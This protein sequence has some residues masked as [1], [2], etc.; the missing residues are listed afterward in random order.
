MRILMICLDMDPRSIQGDQHTGAA[1]LYVR[2]TLDAL[3]ESGIETLAITRHND[4]SK[5]VIEKYSDSV[6]IVRIG[7]G[8]VSVEP[9]E[10]LWGKESISIGKIKAVLADLNF[11]PDIIHSIYWYSGKVGLALSKQLGLPHVYT[12]ISLGKVKHQTLGK[13]LVSHDVDRERTEQECFLQS[14]VIISVCQQEKANLLKL[15]PGVDPDKIVVVGRGIDPDL[16]F[17]TPQWPAE[18]PSIKKPYLF[19]AARLIPSKGLKFLAGVYAR[20]LEDETI[21]DSPQLVIAG[22][23]S[24]E[25]EES[26]LRILTTLRH[27]TAF[28]S[29]M[30]RWLGIVPRDRMPV[31][32]SNAVLTCVPS[33][34][35]PAARVVLESMA[36]ETPVLMTETGYSGEVVL[37]GV[38]GFVAEYGDEALWFNYIRS[39]ITDSVWREKVAARTR[40]SVIPYFSLRE[41][42]ERHIEVYKQVNNQDKKPLAFFN[43]NLPTVHQIHS[44]W[45]VPFDKL[46]GLQLAEIHEWCRSLG[47]DGQISEIPVKH[48]ASS[49]IF[50]LTS[51]SGDYLVKR[52]LGKMHF[53]KLFYPTNPSNEVSYRS[54][55]ARWEAEKT[56]LKGPLFQEPIATNRKLGL[57]LQK[58]AEE[59][60][61]SWNQEKILNL[62]SSVTDFQ[63]DQTNRFVHIVNGVQVPEFSSNPDERWHQLWKYDFHLNRLNANFRA[64]EFWFTPAH[65]KVELERIGL[66]L[67]GDRVPLDSDEKNLLMRHV[68]LLK[69]IIGNK[70]TKS[71]IVWG[72]CRAGH[73]VQ[74]KDRFYGIDSETCSI[75]EPELDFGNFLWDSLKLRENDLNLPLLKI[76][77][78]VIKAMEPQYQSQ[79]LIWI[80]LR[81]FFWLWW[82]ISRS[83]NSRI[84]HYFNLF[85]EFDDM[86]KEMN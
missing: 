78:Q 68:N 22:G 1:H 18:C 71:T 70:E 65:A 80:W 21:N 32:F 64:H 37:S 19:F 57:I 28:R 15:Y 83:R 36:C 39:L 23:T 41:F 44:G 52:P 2:E 17:K 73:V 47:L 49:Q 29:G 8:L 38:N 25:V 31:L 55:V 53:Y 66:C 54:S 77:M 76:V 42:G 79:T 58:E 62:F 86:V 50:K 4:I 10:F 67:M 69:E 51:A 12:I 11:H 75:G 16:F 48:K 3:S 59:I 24:K 30:I 7:V 34:Y 20:L 45:D 72:G 27:Q 84:G 13:K 9:K 40:A 5:P 14:K 82:D 85:K 33:I 43:Q 6:R 46:D 63:R 35:E 74:I 60:P 56:F 61:H 81:N 26:Q